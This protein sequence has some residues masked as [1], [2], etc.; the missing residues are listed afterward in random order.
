[1]ALT[2]AC[3]T[4]PHL[5]VQCVLPP[6]TGLLWKWPCCHERM[7]LGPEVGAVPG[8]LG[9]RGW[10]AGAAGH[11]AG[12][13]GLSARAAERGAD[14]WGWQRNCWSESSHPLSSESVVGQEAGRV[15]C[16][17]LTSM[18][19]EVRE[20]GRTEGPNPV[21]VWEHDS[22]STEGDHTRRPGVRLRDSSDS[23]ASH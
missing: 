17:E 4:T 1:M 6:S 11:R 15:C 5:S 2:A 13:S 10:G 12:G 18:Q 14:M 9:L 21:A 22:A 7:Q 20:A 23:R 8:S 3:H 19:E 16:G